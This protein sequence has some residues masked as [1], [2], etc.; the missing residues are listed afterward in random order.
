LGPAGF[1]SPDDVEML[2]M[3]QEGYNNRIGV[4][5]N[6]ISNGLLKAVPERNDEE[7]MRVFW[8]R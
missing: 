5:W 7:Q 3:C 1:A 2:E 8:R 6:D 4:E